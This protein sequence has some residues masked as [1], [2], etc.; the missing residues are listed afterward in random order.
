VDG[1][2]LRVVSRLTND[3]TPIDQPDYKKAVQASLARIYPRQAG[4]FTQAL[5]E[6]GATVCGPNRKPDCEICPCRGFC[7]A[8][9]Q[10]TQ[11]QLPVKAPKRS[12]REEKLTVFILRAND[13]YAL[14]KRPATGLLAGLW[15]FP[16]VQG[17]LEIS[18]VL[19]KVEE[20]GL[21]PKEIKRQVEK[22]HI[23]THVKW[24]MRGVYLDVKE[25]NERYTW[26]TAQEVETM[27]ALPTAF[28][29][30]WDIGEDNNG[31]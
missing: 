4:D 10:G 25:T 28:R 3:A 21:K 23:F 14:E 13:R 30:F 6:L 27:A 5:M 29:Q 2:V 8:Y 1:N 11:L 18:Q 16:N 7:E 15:Q 22:E 9:S 17:W 31:K 24:H 19:D 12:R 26:L 20:L